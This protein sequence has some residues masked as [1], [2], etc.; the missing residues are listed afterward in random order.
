MPEDTNEVEVQLS[1]APFLFVELYEYNNSIRQVTPVQSTDEAE[2]IA[3]EKRIWDYYGKRWFVAVPV[4]REVRVEY[5]LPKPVEAM[6]GVAPLP[7]GIFSF[8]TNGK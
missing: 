5:G 4:R 3:T 8:G 7:D 1:E 6:P 2:R